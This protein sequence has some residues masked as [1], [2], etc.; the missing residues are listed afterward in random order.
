MEDINLALITKLAWQ[1]VVPSQK[2]WVKL[3]KAKYLRG[4]QV[5]DAQRS[6][7]TFS[8]IWGSI[9]QSIKL[10][11]AGACYQIGAV[12]TL[13]IKRDPWIPSLSGY[14]ST[15]KDLMS[16]DGRRWNSNLVTNIFPNELRDKILNTPILESEQERL[17]GSPSTSGDFSIKA[18]HRLIRQLK[19]T[20]QDN[21][22]KHTWNTI[23]NSS[24]HNRHILLIWKILNHDIPTLDRIQK[25][26]SSSDQLCYLCQHGTE[27]LHHLLL[28][29]PLTKLLWRNSPWQI[30]IESFSALAVDEWVSLVM[31]PNND[32]PLDTTEK[33]KIRQFLVTAFEQVWMERNKVW[34]GAN[35]TDWNE[36]SAQTN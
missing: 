30:K 27:T 14:I 4:K 26:F 35:R 13:E 22:T 31:E 1:M 18:T 25:I 23:W 7:I 24:L 21:T 29:C 6:Q 5:L 32:L 16:Q 15:I 33:S 17:I 19:G 20:E 34:K 28:Q 12:S 36:I 8:W 2:M 11:R 9:L 3:I 10:L